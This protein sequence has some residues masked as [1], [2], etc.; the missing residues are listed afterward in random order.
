MRPRQRKAPTLLWPRYLRRQGRGWDRTASRYGAAVADGARPSL[1]QRLTLPPVLK[2]AP[3][4]SRRKLHRLTSPGGRRG[5][6]DVGLSEIGRR[7]A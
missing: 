5:I 2:P 7:I 4:T 3:T 6:V 1:V